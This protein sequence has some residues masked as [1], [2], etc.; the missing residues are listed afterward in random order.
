MILFVQFMIATI[1]LCPI[2]IFIATLFI[3]R[4]MRLNKHKAIGFAADVTTAMLFISVPLAIRG[5]WDVAIFIPLIVIAL[6]VAIIFTYIDWRTKK[7]IEIKPLLKKIWRI[8]FIVLSIAYFLVWAIGL[9][10]SVMIFMMV[11]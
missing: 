2:I 7:E 4:K 8:Y 11:D 10:H 5:L 3:F 9:T 6:V 1:I